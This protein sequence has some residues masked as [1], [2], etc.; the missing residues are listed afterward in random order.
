MQS[1]YQPAVQLVFDHDTSSE[2]GRHS[3][4]DRHT[5]LAQQ[6]QRP[7]AD[8]PAGFTQ[9]AVASDLGAIFSSF[10]ALEDMSDGE[11]ED[12]EPSAG[13]LSPMQANS[14]DSQPSCEAYLCRAEFV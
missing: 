8:T 12:D 11:E 9:H 13:M 1:S 5:Q 14:V 4:N 7:T 2:N 3:G 6:Q 10:T